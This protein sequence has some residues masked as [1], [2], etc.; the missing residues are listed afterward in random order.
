MSDVFGERKKRFHISFNKTVLGQLSFLTEH[1]IM[2][3]WCEGTCAAF[4]L[5][6][7]LSPVAR[8]K[9]KFLT[10]FNKKAYL[11]AE[12]FLCFSNSELINDNTF[13]L[14]DKK[15]RYRDF[16]QTYTILWRW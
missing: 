14:K 8:S 1:S 3:S 7:T 12:N 2:T 16:K 11:D 9:L 6:L 10:F 5:M 4:G 15:K 13:S